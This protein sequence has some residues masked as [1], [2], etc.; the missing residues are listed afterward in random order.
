LEKGCKYS[1]HCYNREE[2]F[3]GYDDL[4]G[5]ISCKRI[6]LLKKIFVKKEIRGIISAAVAVL[7][8]LDIGS[9]VRIAAG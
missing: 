5:K 9:N 8:F 7:K 1:F 4:R 6:Q 2:L 3:T